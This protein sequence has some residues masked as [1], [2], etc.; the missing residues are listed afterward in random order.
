MASEYGI[1]QRKNAMRIVDPEYGE[2]TV[3]LIDGGGFK[4]A[5]MQVS[6]LYGPTENIRLDYGLIVPHLK[7]DG[8]LSIEAYAELAEQAVNEYVAQYLK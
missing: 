1:I 6:Y 2:F 8:T 7:E 3:T 4:D 5:I